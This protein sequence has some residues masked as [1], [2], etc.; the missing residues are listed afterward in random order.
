MTPA[1]HSLL[2]VL[3]GIIALVLLPQIFSSDA[4]LTTLCLLCIM[5]VLALSYNMLFGQTGLLSFGHAVYYG[6]G[7]FFAIHTMNAVIHARAPVPLVAIPLV[8]GAAGFLSAVIFGWFSTRQGGTAFAMISLGLGE[9]VVAAAALL[10]DF[11]GGESGITTNRAK[12][13]PLFGYHFGSQ[14]ETTYLIGTWCLTCV[15]AMY[16]ITRTPFGRACNAVRENA[17]RAEFVGYDVR[18]IRFLAF[19]FAGAFAGFAGALAAINFE[20]VSVS[21]LTSTQSGM[22]LLMTY[23][24]GI[25]SFFGPAL[26]AM[27]VTWLQVTLSDLTDG[28]LMYLGLS[29]MLV[30]IL[31]PNGLAGWLALHLAASQQREGLRLVPAY[32]LISG[33]ICLMLTGAVMLIELS[34]HLLGG[35]GAAFAVLNL[36]VDSLHALP[37]IVSVILLAVGV[38]TTG[39]CW[40]RVHRVWASLDIAGQR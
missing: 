15:L 16:A 23:I 7:G 3:A 24:G 37:W 1:V 8:G 40:P 39:R 26:G 31:L 11:F 28:W 29:F 13:L 2:A 27:L 9:L 20:L 5:V 19:C 17:E 18:R 14:L 21:T 35:S 4:G 38:W 12:L 6:L 32:L 34:Y 22:I 10:Q 25:S 33:P 36:H 30:V